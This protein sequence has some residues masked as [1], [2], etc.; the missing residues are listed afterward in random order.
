MHV[1]VRVFK[2]KNCIVLNHE[3]F[4]NLPT[5]P[6]DPKVLWLY[7]KV[8]MYNI[9]AKAMALK[10][11]FDYYIHWYII[12][13]SAVLVYLSMLIIVCSLRLSD[14]LVV[15]MLDMSICQLSHAYSRIDKTR[16]L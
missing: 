13:S 15:Y 3:L 12:R 7:S 10:M 6:Q 5:D 8:E 14:L 1:R 16:C 11:L 4:L 9:P 2:K